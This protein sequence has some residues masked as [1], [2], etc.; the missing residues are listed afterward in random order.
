MGRIIVGMVRACVWVGERTN[1]WHIDNIHTHTFIL[2]TGLFCFGF[3]LN[4]CRRGPYRG[5]GGGIT[6]S[7][8]LVALR[9]GLDDCGGCDGMIF[10]TCM[11]DHKM[12]GSKFCVLRIVDYLYHP[13]TQ[14]GL[15]L[16]L[17]Y[18]NCHRLNA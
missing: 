11:V 2:L 6:F 18:R 14:L 1:Q 13:H 17:F 15:G 9:S 16:V 7:V 12:L 5:R 8:S 10:T 3:S 4:R